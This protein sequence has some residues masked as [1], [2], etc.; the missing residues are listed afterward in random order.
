V[1]SMK[2]AA[3]IDENQPDIVHALRALGAS[4]QPLHAVGGG[5]PDLL[6]GFRGRNFLLEVKNPDKP[7]GDQKLTPKQITWHTGWQGQ[8]SIV[9]SVTEAQQW[10]HHQ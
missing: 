7:K 3:R 2:R 10:L 9:R 6:V 8:V 1:W 5:C 4:V